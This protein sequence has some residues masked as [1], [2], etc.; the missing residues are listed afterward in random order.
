MAPKRTS[1]TVVLAIT[2]AAIRK[3]VVDS[4]ATALEAQTTNMAN[5]DNTYR[6]IKPR[7]ALVARKC[8]YKEFMSYQPFNFK[9]TKGAVRLICWFERTESV[10]S[11]SNCTE[12]SKVKFATGTLSKEALSWWNS[13]AQPIGIEEAYK[14]TW[15]EFKKL[16]I[17][18]YC[19]RTEEL[20]VLCPTMVTNSEKMMEVFIGGLPRSIE[21][22]VTASKPQTLKEAITITRRL[23]DHVIKHNSTQGTNDQK[24][25]FDDRRTFTN[26]N[27]YHNNHNNN[28]RS[29]DHHQQKNR[30]QETIR[31]YATTL[32]KNHRARSEGFGDVGCTRV[33]WGRRVN[34]ARIL[35]GKSVTDANPICTLGDYS[36]PSHKGYRNTI[37]LVEGNNVVPLRS[38][39]I[40]LVQ[41]GCSFHGLR[42]EDPNQHLKDFLKLVDLLNLNGD[43]RERMRL[44]KECAC[45][46]FNFS[47]A[48]KLEIGLNVFQQDLSPHGRI[49]LIVFLLNS[50]HREGLQ[51]SA[52]TSLCSNN[53]KENLFLQ[54]GFVSR[55]YSKKSLIMASIF[56]SKSKSFMT[57]SIPSQDEPLINRPMSSIAEQN[58]NLS[59]PKCVHFINLIVILNKKDEAKEEGN[60]KSITTKYEDHELTLESEKEFEEKTKEEI[61]EEEEDSPKHF[62]TFPL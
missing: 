30:R 56:D 53:I 2:Q 27:N 23:M 18:K 10:F 42:F 51:N 22:N 7:E 1:T 32:N 59:S 25:K 19:P 8:S 54:H 35:A 14:V 24:R 3:L 48:I 45:V 11:R 28:N 47:F 13:F 33:T 36:K 4:V 37:E 29:N 50:F 60:V 26:N 62:D 40:R 58:R 17:K 61:K 57:M 41:N 44:W 15:S 5:A 16:L 20:A 31:A 49:L 43:N 52:M 46:N 39:T 21:V 34:S 55:T 9:G 12:E 38:D 6:N